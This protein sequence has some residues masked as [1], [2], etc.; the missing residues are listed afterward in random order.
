[1]SKK[2]PSFFSFFP[3]P[4]PPLLPNPATSHFEVLQVYVSFPD[5]AGEPPRNLR[6]FRK[7]AVPCG[8]AEKEGDVAGVSVEIELEQRAFE[9]WSNEAWSF[10]PGPA[11]SY[12]IAVGAS[13][14]DIRLE[15][16]VDLFH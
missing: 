11:G 7:V 13:S 4:L 15:A 12:A 14:R 9:V 16:T 10:V 1:M 5:G 8:D 3:H 2:T 6:A